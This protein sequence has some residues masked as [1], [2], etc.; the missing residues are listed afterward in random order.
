MTLGHWEDDDL[1][2]V[3]GYSGRILA[4]LGGYLRPYLP[5]LAVMLVI[6]IVASLLEAA[7]PLIVR[8]AVDGYIQAGQADGLGWLVLAYVGTLLG[9]FVLFFIQA[10]L[11]TYVTQRVM[12]DMRLQLFQHVEKMSIAYF[13]RNPVGRLV[14]RLTNDVSTIE[15]VLSQGVVEALYSVLFL[16]TIIAAMFYLDWRL[17]LVMLIFVP[18]LVYFVRRFAIALRDTFRLQRAWLARVNAF[19]NENITG[20]AVVQLFNRQRRNLGRFD[21]RNRGLLGANLQATFYYAAFEPT[22]VAFNAITTAVIIWYG[23]G[24]A[25]DEALTLGTLIA[26]LQYMQRFYWPVRDI[27]ERFTNLQQ[28]VASCERIFGVLDEPEEVTDAP[29]ARPLGRIEGRVEFRNVWFAY[30]EDNWV[31]RNVSFAIAPGE[32]VAIVGA[33]GAGKST[34]MNLLNRF[35]DVQRGDIVIDG[36]SVRDLRQRELR[37]QVGMVLQDPFIFT[38]SVLENVRLRDQTIPA[39]QVEAAAQQVGADIFINRMPLGYESHLAERGANLS[40]GQKQLI[41]LARVAAFDPKIVLVMDEA[42]ASIDPETEATLQRSMREV[43]TG[44]TSIIIA[45]RLNTIR[46]VDRILVLQQG[47]VVE[48]GTHAELLARGGTYARLYELQYKDQDVG[49]E[50]S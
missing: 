4:R 8:R 37:R 5:L 10:L 50:G 20:M 49:V 24:R 45:H 39:A 40:T 47:E 35:Y 27:S 48:E 38:D 30:D 6:V 43:M 11:I 36:V 28:A 14:T 21:D 42:T 15:Q 19:L 46:H 12:M 18:G 1:D 26:F 44:R 16:V 13:D 31:L 41:A 29:G 9:V 7:G 22:V 17:A 34:M 33:T 2:L 3:S 25:L 32:A 23:G